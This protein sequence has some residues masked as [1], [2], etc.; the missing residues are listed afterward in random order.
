MTQICIKKDKETCLSF[1]DTAVPYVSLVSRVPHLC[2][3][4]PYSVIDSCICISLLS[5]SLQF[6]LLCHIHYAAFWVPLISKPWLKAKE[7]SDFFNLLSILWGGYK[8]LQAVDI[9]GKKYSVFYSYKMG[10]KMV[11]GWKQFW[12]DSRSQ[13]IITL[14]K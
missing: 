1:F 11:N 9:E 7:K 12:R 4:L 6:H 8:M 5:G 13:I 10:W 14:F 2:L 3:P